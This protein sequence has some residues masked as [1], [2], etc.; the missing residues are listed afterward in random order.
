MKT[1][2]RRGVTLI[3]TVLLLGI[4]AAIS[5]SLAVLAYN[6]FSYSRAA[7]ERIQVES[8]IRGSLEKITE[9]LRRAAPS[10]AGAYPL[11]FFSDTN[12]DGKKERV[13]YFLD[14]EILKRGI[15]QSAGQP[16]AY[17]LASER[18]TLLAN[19]IKNSSVFSY[20][21]GTYSGSGPPLVF[22]VSASDVRLIK[23]SLTIGVGQDL[24][25]LNTNVVLRSLR[26]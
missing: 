26:D 16:P 2:E 9:E 13:R 3:E 12:N 4:S 22:P 23:I 17:N 7:G 18:I 25:N 8:Q 11:V 15:I 19:F 24:L 10:D 6:F 21:D 20:Y 1:N 14:G 5:V